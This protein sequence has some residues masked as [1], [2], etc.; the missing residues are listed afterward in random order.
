MRQPLY[1][2][3]MSDAL[4]RL[5]NMSE[6]SLLSLMDALYGRG[7]LKYGDGRAELLAEAQRQV[8]REFTNMHPDAVEERKY[9]TA[10]ATAARRNGGF[11]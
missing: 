2:E 7:D 1:H 4:A 10:L 11:A 6:T 5:E 3:G 8:R 9:L